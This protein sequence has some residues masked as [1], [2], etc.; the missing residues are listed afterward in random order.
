MKPSFNIKELIN[1]YNTICIA[2]HEKPDGDAIGSC[3]AMAY[4][5]KK[6]GKNPIVLLDKYNEK[7]D[8]FPG[9]EFLRYDFDNINSDVFICLDC[10]DVKRITKGTDKLFNKSKIKINID[11]HISNDSYADYNFVALDVSSTSEAVYEILEDIIQI[12]KP[13]AECIYGGIIY[14]SGGLRLKTTSTRT[15]EIASKM[16]SYGIDY[17]NI[18]STLIFKNTYGEIESLKRVLSNMKFYANNKIVISTF[19]IKELTELGL[20]QDDLDKTV[21]FLASIYNVEVAIF[22][23]ERE[24][25]FFKVSLRSSEQDISKIALKFGGGGHK[26]AAGFT[27]KDTLEQTIETIKNEIMLCM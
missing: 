3:M 18:Y 6:L 21:S 2:G 24:P 16:M 25:N 4:A 10:G 27:S 7:Y 11:H 12:D 22:I 9:K 17:S 15:M 19:T 13:I 14:D 8:V 26:N 20:K 1:D 5:I 23:Y